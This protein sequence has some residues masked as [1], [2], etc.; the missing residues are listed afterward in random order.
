MQSWGTTSRLS[1]SLAAC[2]SGITY[3]WQTHRA[4]L[5]VSA[6]LRVN[7]T[8]GLEVDL[9]KCFLVS[10]GASTGVI[11]SMHVCHQL[12]LSKVYHHALHKA[13]PCKLIALPLLQV[14][15]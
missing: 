10:H 8:S 11:A 7:A 12:Q 9:N 4:V 15:N 2:T 6:L 13:D 3:C 1:L 5:L 14:D